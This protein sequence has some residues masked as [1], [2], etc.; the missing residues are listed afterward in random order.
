LVGPAFYNSQIV[1]P[2][3]VKFADIESW[4][5]GLK[6]LKEALVLKGNEVQLL[7]AVAFVETLLN[8]VC[9]ARRVSALLGHDAGDLLKENFVVAV[10]LAVAGF[11]LHGALAVVDDDGLGVL[12]EAGGDG[13]D[14]LEV[15]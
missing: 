9:L 10:N 11:P 15:G 6:P 7:A 13:L 2:V 14:V 5:F 12:H 3:S 4:L 8:A 1:F